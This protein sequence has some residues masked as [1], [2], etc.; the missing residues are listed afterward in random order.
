MAGR[1][2][3][4]LGALAL[5]GGYGLLRLGVDAYGGREGRFDFR[6]LARPEGFRRLVAGEVSG[7]AGG[8]DP[9]IG[10]DAGPSPA[11][12][13]INVEARLCEALFGGRDGTDGVVPVAYFSDYNCPYCRVLSERLL[14]FEAAG[15]DVAVT[16]HE[17][18]LLGEASRVAA[19]AAL[20][21][22]RQGA[23]A[24]FHER[25][26]GSPALPTEAHLRALAG[27]LGLDADRLVR[28]MTSAA[29]AREVAVS[30]AL[31][32]LFAAV[33]TPLLV[34]GRT[35]VEGAV[36]EATLRRLIAEERAAG[37]VPGCA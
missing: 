25:L 34:V 19:R 8:F 12:E 27:G 22:R 32:G 11:V 4:L 5:A 21:A 23:Y 24:A 3:L 35:V 2:G 7:A 33:G 10:L 36:G 16:W 6:P 30:E 18:P 9:L 28:D 17:W 37:R 31:A 14:A 1:R 29:V 13:P 20:A 26:M 15:T